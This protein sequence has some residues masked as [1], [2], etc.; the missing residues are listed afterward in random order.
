M[1][2]LLRQ[3]YHDDPITFHHYEQAVDDRSWEVRATWSWSPLPNWGHLLG[4]FAETTCCR[5]SICLIVV[6][7]GIDGRCKYR[8]L[9]PLYRLLLSLKRRGWIWNR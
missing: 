7:D 8:L 1:H 3:K 9:L 2:L 5:E 6:E 4:S